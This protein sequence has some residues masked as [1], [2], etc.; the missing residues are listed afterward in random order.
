[1]VGFH[2]ALL[3]AATIGASVA[4]SRVADSPCEAASWLM[5]AGCGALLVVA[6][7]AR[8]I[9]ESAR[10][11]AVSADT[12]PGRAREDMVR[13]RHKGLLRWAVAFCV[14]CIVGAVPL[15]ALG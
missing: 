13:T 15:Y 4:G 3:V 11:L 9:E 5:L 2:R 7:L 10:A 12:D 8:D 6:D 1:M 14:A